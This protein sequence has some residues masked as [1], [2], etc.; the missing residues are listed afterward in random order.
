MKCPGRLCVNEY[1]NWKCARC[2]EVI[3]YQSNRLFCLCGSGLAQTS[4]YKCSDALHERTPIAKE[5]IYLELNQNFKSLIPIKKSEVLQLNG[6]TSLSVTT[7][8]NILSTNTFINLFRKALVVSEF[9]DILKLFVTSAGLNANLSFST[10]NID[11]TTSLANSYHS[12]INALCFLLSD[13]TFNQQIVKKIATYKH[14]ILAYRTKIYLINLKTTS[15]SKVVYQLGQE[16][17]PFSEYFFDIDGIRSHIDQYN[18]SS[19][20]PLRA[21]AL[22]DQI[23]F[24]WRQLIEEFTKLNTEIRAEPI[25]STIFANN[26]GLS[27][28][29]LTVIPTDGIGKV[30]GFS[31]EVYSGTLQDLFTNPNYSGTKRTDSSKYAT[32]TNYILLLT[33]AVTAFN[34]TSMKVFEGRLTGP[35]VLAFDFYSHTQTTNWADGIAVVFSKTGSPAFDSTLTGRSKGYQTLTN[36]I[37]VDFGIN[38]LPGKDMVVTS[39]PTTSTPGSYSLTNARNSMNKCYLI[40]NEK[41]ISLFINNIW[42]LNISTD[43]YGQLGNDITISVNGGTG[44]EKMNAEVANLYLMK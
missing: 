5:L 21:S 11:S 39:Y 20:N 10:V 28:N 27:T 15:D 17:I 44:S 42:A 35:W 7:S 1:K 2:Q 8:I 3:V 43:I 12:K 23:Q 25:N 38:F 30:P 14:S 6:T 24:R 13:S 16:K 26:A 18:A 9:V 31:A 29:P 4:M 22:K 32:N 19:A 37:A 33:T 40:Y 41:M 36:I 34:C